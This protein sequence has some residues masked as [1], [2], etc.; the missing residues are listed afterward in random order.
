M[1]CVSLSLLV[2][3]VDQS[4]CEIPDQFVVGEVA[5][6]IKA[7]ETL[8]FELIPVCHLDVLQQIFVHLHSLQYLQ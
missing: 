4:H 6:L 7:V 8:T 5:V 1:I 2:P 3:V